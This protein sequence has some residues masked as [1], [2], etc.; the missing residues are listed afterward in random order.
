MTRPVNIDESKVM[1]VEAQERKAGSGATPAKI[2]WG[3]VKKGLAHDRRV[4]SE[5]KMIRDI[6]ERG[7]HYFRMGEEEKRRKKPKPGKGRSLTWRTTW[8]DLFGDLAD[9]VEDE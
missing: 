6:S 3:R 4:R 7:K 9:F 5:D 8:E 1:K 2:N